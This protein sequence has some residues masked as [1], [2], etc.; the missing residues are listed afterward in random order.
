M[1]HSSNSSEKEWKLMRDCQTIADFKDIEA[2]PKRYKAA[3]DYAEK[4]VEEKQAEIDKY[5]Y[6]IKDGKEELN[7]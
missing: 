5:K 6:M 4:C 2:D 7:E 3:L 1:I